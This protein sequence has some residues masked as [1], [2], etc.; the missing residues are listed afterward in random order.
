MS[1]ASL[2]KTPCVNWISKDDTEG[3]GCGC[4][5]LLL[6]LLAHIIYSPFE[7][8]FHSTVFIVKNNVC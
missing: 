1:S 5:L 4:C 3:M 8:F 7:F 6:L 2:T